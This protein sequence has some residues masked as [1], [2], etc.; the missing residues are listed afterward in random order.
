MIDYSNDKKKIVLIGAGL[1][2]MSFA[3]ALLG[4]HICEELGIIDI[5]KKRAEGEAM[6]LSHGLAFSG[7]NMKTPV[8]AVKPR[9]VPCRPPAWM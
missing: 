3:Y 4:S 2:G 1:V 5:D 6:D 9:S 8:P 7:G